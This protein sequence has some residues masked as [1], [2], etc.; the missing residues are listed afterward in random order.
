[1]TKIPSKN[2]VPNDVHEKYARTKDINDEYPLDACVLAQVQHNELSVRIM[3]LK[4]KVCNGKSYLC[5]MY[6]T[7]ELVLYNNEIDVP[8]PLRERMLNWYHHHLSYPGFIYLVNTVQQLCNG[9]GLVAY[10][11]RLVSKC[12]ICK[13]IINK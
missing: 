10:C 11:V 6:D 4:C 3:E 2:S 8:Q 5:T 7:H 1:M 12:A 13:K 9:P